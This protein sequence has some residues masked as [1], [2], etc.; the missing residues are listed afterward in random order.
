MYY[1]WETRVRQAGDVVVEDYPPSFRKER[2]RL[3]EGRRMVHAVPELQ[4]RIP[5]PAGGTL[6]DDLV[7][8][9]RRCLVHSNRLAETLRRAGVD[10]IDYYPC[11]LVDAA[12][13][14]PLARYQVANLLDV[15]HCLDFEASELDIDD[16]EPSE[17]WTIE[18]MKLR[19]DRLGDSLMF[20]LGER[21]KT[22]IVHERVKQAVEREGLRGPVF[23]PADGYEEYGGGTGRNPFNLI[24]THADDPDGEAGAWLDD[25][26]EQGA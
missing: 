15:I 13:G 4:I 23:L 5:M 10:G 17:I 18:R 19:A 2:L 22:V 21:R 16:E 11:M 1:V 6:T 14:E 12:S 8:R 25:A 24:G 9:K 7:L 26:A 3:L 20:R